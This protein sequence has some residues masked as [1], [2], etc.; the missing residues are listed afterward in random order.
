MISIVS[1]VFV[2]SSSVIVRRN[3]TRKVKLIHSSQGKIA[4]LTILTT[5]FV[6]IGVIIFFLFSEVGLRFAEINLIMQTFWIGLVLVSMWIRFK[7][8]YFVHEIT[9]LIVIC[10]LLVSFSAVLFM[11]P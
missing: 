2:V 1:A 10:A 4:V 6:T 11:G 5:V 8:N 9:M 7:G 3:R